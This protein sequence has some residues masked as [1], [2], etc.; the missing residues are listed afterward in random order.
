MLI[1]KATNGFLSVL[2]SL[3][4]QFAMLLTFLGIVHIPYD[5]YGQ[6]DIASLQLYH[7]VWVMH[8]FLITT[9]I[10]NR[11]FS[12]GLGI[13]KVTL[14]T[15]AMLFEV[16]I[17]IYICVDWIF[18]DPKAPIVSDPEVRGAVDGTVING[19]A[20]LEID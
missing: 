10:L 11:Y 4:V 6:T 17:L 2:G 14:T 12:E 18:P 9:I 20:T 5:K 19:E 13:A 1:N 8:L 3:P 16:L 7:M 15:V